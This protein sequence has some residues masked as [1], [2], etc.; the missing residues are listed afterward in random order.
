MLTFA[1]SGHKW[2]ATLLHTDP[3][4]PSTQSSIIYSNLFVV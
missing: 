4:S 3:S 2:T 1:T